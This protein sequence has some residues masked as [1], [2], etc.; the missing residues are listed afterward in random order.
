[1][2][3]DPALELHERRHPGAAGPTRPSVE[4]L[5]A[6]VAFDCEHVTQSFF[7][8]VRAPQPRVG[9]GD[10]VELMALTAGEITRVLPQRVARLG[11]VL[12]VAGRATLPCET[13]G[14]ATTFG[15]V[16]CSPPFDVEGLDR[17]RD[18]MER[19]GAPQRVRGPR[20]DNS[21]D[22]VRHIR[23][24]MGE[25]GGSLGTEL[26]EEH[27]SAASLRPGPAHTSRPLS[28]S[29]TTM[30]YRWPRL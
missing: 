23:R 28:W 7:E 22:P 6:F 26:I 5:F 8:E 30:R 29:T 19:V 15:F 14:R 12:C 27:A 24:N 18:D 16:P 11:D 25:Q 4:C 9:L 13:A 1:M 3:G 10:P 21:G 17:P 20:R 2:R